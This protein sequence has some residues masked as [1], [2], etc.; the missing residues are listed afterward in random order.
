MYVPT[1]NPVNIREECSI[2]KKFPKVTLPYVP[3]LACSSTDPKIN[4][5]VVTSNF[6]LS[7]TDNQIFQIRE[8]KNLGHIIEVLIYLFLLFFLKGLWRKISA[9][10]HLYCSL[11]IS[12]AN[13]KITNSNKSFDLFVFAIFPQRGLCTAIRRQCK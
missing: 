6:I 1:T 3:P 11:Y 5:V 4:F 7:V 13:E 9:S 2:P 10:R 12:N 8:E